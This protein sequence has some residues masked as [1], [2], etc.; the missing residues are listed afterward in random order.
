M[1]QGTGKRMDYDLLRMEVG[2]DRALGGLLGAGSTG[3]GRRE[4]TLGKVPEKGEWRG[5]SAHPEAPLGRGRPEQTGLTAQ[6]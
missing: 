3:E 2:K 4:M 5:V 6:R 1:N